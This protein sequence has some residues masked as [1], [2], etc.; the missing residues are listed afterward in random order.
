MTTV[1]SRDAPEGP[2]SVEALRACLPW[3]TRPH[4][5]PIVSP[6]QEAEVQALIACAARGESQ[7]MSRMYTLLWP[8]LGALAERIVGD[9]N[10]A[11]EVVQDVL[12]KVW[13]EAPHYQRELGSA[14]GWIIV[15]T[16]NRALDVRRKKLRTPR[17]SAEASEHLLQA[18]RS[19][20]PSPEAAA[21]AQQSRSAITHALALLRPEQQR[22]IELS[23][24][25]GCSHGEIAAQLGWP[26]G[27]VKTRL[28]VAVRALRRDL[29][30]DSEAS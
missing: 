12:L 23:Y 17:Q 29:S 7:A 24:F 9:E 22:L 16:R 14:I 1:S 2:A 21:S 26:L 25:Q 15:L 20:E 19:E 4:R 11:R 3:A 6:A 27:T 13:R 10:D 8:M 28:S 18:L 30:N 5:A